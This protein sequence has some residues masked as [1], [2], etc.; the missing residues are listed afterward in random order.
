MNSIPERRVRD[1]ASRQ[2]GTVTRHQALAL[3]MTARMVDTR[4][5]AG[6]WDRLES[7]VYAVFP[8]PDSIRPL[9]V[10]VAKL[11]AV[12]SHESAGELHG[13]ASVPH[14]RV[15]VTVRHRS[16]NRCLGVVVHESTDLAVEYVERVSELPVTTVAR[17]IV[18]LAS[19]MRP[20]RYRRLVDD[21][22]ASQRI[23]LDELG[24][25]FAA[26]GRRGRPGTAMLREL[27]SEIGPGHIPAESELEHRLRDLL[28]C[29]EM[30][31]PVAQL[32]LP[33]RTPTPG[34]VDF[35]YP[36]H[37]VIIECDGRRWHTR[38]DAFEIDRRRD[39]LA[40]L[41]GWRVLRFTWGDV[42]D[43]PGDVLDAV[44]GVLR[45]YSSSA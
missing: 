29:A 40:Q 18:D 44:T 15:V 13:L 24:A 3:G 1:L 32:P 9:A 37:R 35:A 42:V 31:P 39:N 14:G 2:A 33:W 6:I 45:V 5:R 26:L 7:G 21:A 12:V 19:V 10:A 16:T 34:R 28:T 4:L 41:A 22:L 43:R 30:P 27:L 8:V 36:E 23:D 25:V 17:T 20:R 11:P 38:A